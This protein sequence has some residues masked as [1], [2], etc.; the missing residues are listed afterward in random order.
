MRIGTKLKQIRE[1]RKMSQ[2]ELAAAL[3]TTQKTIS[4]WESDKGLPTL[5]QLSKIEKI[6]QVDVLSWLE[7]GGIT[8]NQNSKNHTILDNTH[9]AYSKLIKQYEKFINEKD[10]IIEKQKEIIE[11]LIKNIK[12]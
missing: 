10:S 9:I 4:N 11:T 3:D 2:S 8:F 1:N 6:L 12:S 5:F 7:D